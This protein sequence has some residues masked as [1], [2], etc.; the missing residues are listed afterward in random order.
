MSD[1]TAHP[2]EPT[3]PSYAAWVDR[4]IAR[5]F[6]RDH[7]ELV[8]EGCR[9]S[10]LVGQY[11]TP[12]YLYSQAVMAASWQQLRH[13]FPEPFRILYSMKAN[14]HPAILSFFLERGAGI[15]IASAGE[16]HGARQAGCLAGQMVY[17]GPGKQDVELALALQAGVGAIHVESLGELRRIAQLATSLGIRAPVGLRVNPRLASAVGSLQMG[18][19]PTQFGIDEERLESVLGE[20]DRLTA[21]DFVGL[22]LNTGTQLLDAPTLLAY[23]RHALEL[24][25]RTAA[26]RRQP[27]RTLDF[28]GGFGI[29]YFQG[30]AELDTDRLAAG[31]GALMAEYAGAAERSTT[32]YLIEPG[33]Y[34]VGPAGVYVTRVVDVK[35]SRDQQFVVLD[36]GMHHHLA[37][38]GN[39]G[40]TLRRAFPLAVLNRLDQPADRPV[41]VVGPLCTPLDTLGKQLAL[42]AI[43]VGDLVGIFQSGAYARTASPLQFLGHPSPP[44]VWVAGDT[45]RLIRRRGVWQDSLADVVPPLI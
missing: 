18:G 9:V 37:A 3:T 43:E 19:R 36:G 30:Q 28:G 40:Q 17:A 11:G 12:V 16:L 27:L 4:L 34:L 6:Q 13:V 26:R 21:I 2:D 33:R 38:S 20:L 44:E 8:I 25:Q 7:G 41:T 35:T 10:D 29:P 1:S 22:H 45:A 31:V 5:H 24:A 39:F 14:P 42:P 23:Y 15:E 32:E